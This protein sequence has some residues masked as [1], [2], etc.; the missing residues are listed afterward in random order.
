MTCALR[1]TESKTITVGPA[2]TTPISVAVDQA[3]DTIYV[4]DLQK[5][6]KESGA[7][8]VVNGASCARGAPAFARAGMRVMEGEGHAVPIDRAQVL[9][10]HAA[11]PASPP[12]ALTW[13]RPAH[14]PRAVRRGS[15]VSR[16]PGAG[17]QSGG[18]AATGAP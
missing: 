12:T 6:A 9:G 18:T 17:V 1:F 4:A 14:I 13:S 2:F 5:R 3:T 15:T 11:R 16:R 8:S 10:A 7:M